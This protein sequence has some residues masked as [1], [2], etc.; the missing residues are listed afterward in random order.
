MDLVM[1]LLEALLASSPDTQIGSRLAAA[2]AA[3][4]SSPAQAEAE[5][6]DRELNLALQESERQAAARRRERRHTGTVSWSR[7]SRNLV[8]HLLAMVDTCSGWPSCLTR[9]HIQL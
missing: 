7:L 8:M 5:D 1:W 2:L 6:E 3:S 4:L 9:L